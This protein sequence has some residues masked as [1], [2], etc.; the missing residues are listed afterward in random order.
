M[1]I[2]GSFIKYNKPASERVFLFVLSAPRAAA[3]AKAIGR[4]YNGI[5]AL[6]GNR[7]NTGASPTIGWNDI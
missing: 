2:S 7:N 6:A 1:T 5:T 3:P 4:L